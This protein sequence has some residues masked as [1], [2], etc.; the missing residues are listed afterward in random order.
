MSYARVLSPFVL[1]LALFSCGT[2]VTQLVAVIDSDM[3]VPDP[4]ARIR[5]R[6]LRADADVEEELSSV[7][8]ELDGSTTL[9]IA[10]A[11]EPFDAMDIGRVIIEAEAQ[12]AAGM[13]LVAQRATTE[14]REGDQ[15]AV[16]F[17]LRDSCRRVTCPVGNTCGDMGCRSQE[18]PVGELTSFEGMLGAP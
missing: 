14:F 15:L 10:V 5:V 18:V 11:V 3:A 17:L 13:R 7:I 8:V 6:S 9:P 2:P 1:S 4:V 12:S 16:P